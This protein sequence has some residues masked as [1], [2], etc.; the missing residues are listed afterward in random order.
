MKRKVGR[1]AYLEEGK[2]SLEDHLLIL[3]FSLLC[4]V[5]VLIGIEVL[6]VFKGKVRK[7]L[8]EMKNNLLYFE[9]FI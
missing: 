1:L 2:Y 8:G 5:M 4:M 7:S 9:F 6:N 3:F